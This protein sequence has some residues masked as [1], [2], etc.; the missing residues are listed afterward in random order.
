MACHYARQHPRASSQWCGA[1]G[2][3]WRVDVQSQMCERNVSVC[4]GRV[5]NPRPERR[6]G[7]GDFIALR[8]GDFYNELNLNKKIELLLDLPWF[9]VSSPAPKGYAFPVTGRLVSTVQVT[10]SLSWCHCESM[11][12]AS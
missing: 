12:L 10:R 3:E 4:T 9:L 6:F 11:L 1:C 2:P 8:H 7:Q 5:T